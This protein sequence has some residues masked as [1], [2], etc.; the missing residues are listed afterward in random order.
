[1]P[2]PNRPAADIINNDVQREHQFD[3]TF[4]ATFVVDNEQLLTAEQRNVYDQI[5]VSI[6]AR[7]GGFFFLDAPGGTGKT[8]LI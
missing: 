2:A 6:A 3:M 1:M 8:F 7:Q 5:N 4:L